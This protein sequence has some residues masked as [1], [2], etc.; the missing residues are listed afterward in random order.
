[1][2]FDQMLDTDFLGRSSEVDMF[3]LTHSLLA[4]SLP[5]AVMTLAP[6]AA[7]ADPG[8]LTI[9]VGATGTLLDPTLVRVP[10]ELTCAPMEIG[11]NQ[12]SASLRQAVSG[13]VAFGSGF[14][15]N[16]MVCD[17]TPHAVSYLIW[18]DTAS[19]APFRRGDATVQIGAFLCPPAPTPIAD[20]QSGSSGVQVIRLKR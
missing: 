12:G 15:E 7:G 20:C 1:M 10:A 17:G 19:P 4:L 5:V 11:S 16:P 9:T 13:R 6:V 3:T 14:P 8:T 18:V 2:P